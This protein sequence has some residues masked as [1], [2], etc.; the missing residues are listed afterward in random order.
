MKIVDA[1]FVVIG[2]IS[3][4]GGLVTAY[5]FVQLGR[6]ME[7]IQSTAAGANIAGAQQAISTLNMV[8]V[9]GWIWIIMVLLSSGYTIWLGVERIRSKKK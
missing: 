8:I 9:L 5:V 4:I 1:I 2:I 6:A 7:I 3:F